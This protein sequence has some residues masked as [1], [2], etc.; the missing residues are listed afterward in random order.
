[1][2]LNALII[3][4]V[5]FATHACIV[6]DRLYI[7]RIKCPNQVIYCIF[8]KRYWK[9]NWHAWE[10][11]IT[12]GRWR[13]YFTAMWSNLSTIFYLQNNFIFW[14]GNYNKVID[15]FLHG[16]N[17]DIENF[18]GDT[19]LCES[20]FYGIFLLKIDFEDKYVPI[21]MDFIIFTIMLLGREDIAKF[22]IRIG[23][24]VNHH[25]S[26]LKK[27]PINRAAMNGIS[28]NRTRNI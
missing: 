20:A 24:N 23:A 5:Y 15:Y 16:E 3:R 6:Y 19:P 4:Q 9:T 11:R 12:C 28:F 26:L 14:I 22:L 8:S 18:Y 7:M 10:H 13:R 2:Q 17:M 21:I 27:T 1:M 25:G